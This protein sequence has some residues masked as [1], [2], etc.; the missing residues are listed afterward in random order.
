MPEIS[1]CFGLEGLI[2]IE[3]EI[4]KLTKEIEGLKKDL[5]A[6]EAA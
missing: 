4:E 2:D 3:Q 5:K 6:K 1:R